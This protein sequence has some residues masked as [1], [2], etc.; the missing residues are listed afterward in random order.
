LGAVRLVA[1]G[2]VRARIIVRSAIEDI[3]AGE[4]PLGQIGRALDLHGQAAKA[5]DAK[6]KLAGIPFVIV[7][8]LA[9]ST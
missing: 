3:G 2:R 4:L 5:G 7:L 1:E 8:S 6:T 9:F